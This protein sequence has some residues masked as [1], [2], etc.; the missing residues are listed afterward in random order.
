M[1]V[2]FPLI[3]VGDTKI[4]YGCDFVAPLILGQIETGE[5]RVEIFV[6]FLMKNI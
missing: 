5:F 6:I 2:I 4:I 1:L 3:L